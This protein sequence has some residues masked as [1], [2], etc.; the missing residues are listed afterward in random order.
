MTKVPSPAEAAERWDQN[1]T[2]WALKRAA[3]GQLAESPPSALWAFDLDLRKVSRRSRKTATVTL[4]QV[5]LQHLGVEIG[6][7]LKI[8]PQRNGTL[9]IRKATANDFRQLNPFTRLTVIP[10]KKSK[11]AAS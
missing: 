1:T 8:I 9:T 4:G 2:R 3:Q 5:H 11:K 7:H 10:S 6:D